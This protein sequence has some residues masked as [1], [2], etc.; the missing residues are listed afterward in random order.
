MKTEVSLEKVVQ[1]TTGA[2]LASVLARSLAKDYYTAIVE[3]VSNS[4]DADSEEVKISLN[5]NDDRLVISDDGTGMDKEGIDSFF[6]L[7]DSDKIAHPFTAKGRKK[8]GK[9]G[10]AT[11]LLEYLA[12]E[13]VLDTYKDGRRR[14]VREKFS[15]T[16]AGIKPKEE[17]YEADPDKHGT[18]ITLLGLNFNTSMLNRKKLKRVL[19]WQVP[20]LPDFNIHL[21]G[22]LVPKR[23]AVTYC[24]EFLLEEEISGIG[25]VVGS[26]YYNHRQKLDCPGIFIYVNGRAVGDPNSFNLTNFWGGLNGKVLGMIHADGLEPHIGFDR[27]RFAEDAEEYVAVREA[28][29]KVLWSVTHAAKNF[30]SGRKFYGDKRRL[31]KIRKVL[32]DVEAQINKALLVDE[33]SVPYRLEIEIDD[34]R[35]WLSRYDEDKGTVYINATNPQLAIAKSRIGIE[36]ALRPVFL[37]LALTAIADYSLVKD[38]LSNVDALDTFNQSIRQVSEQLYSG[39]TPIISTVRADKEDNKAIPLNKLSLNQHR[40]YTIPEIIYLTGRFPSTIKRLYKSGALK[41]YRVERH[42]KFNSRSIRSCLEMVEGHVPV[43][44]VLDPEFYRKDVDNK[45][46]VG[47]IFMPFEAEIAQR[48]DLNEYTINVGSNCPHVWVLED[49]VMEFKKAFLEGK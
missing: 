32:K 9:K 33:S 30:V 43:G 39:M 8:I 16:L 34:E 36:T 6:R 7:G 11:V 12:Q 28:I 42:T 31:P 46:T 44:L 48:T 41:P 40:L 38:G 47:D 35:N 17:V 13:Y 10:V 3:L 18:T 15:D 23:N 20:S 24:T 27:S 14:V 26:I 5:F 25:K 19:E 4:Y 29:E 22:I 2:N 45:K 49:K 21:D 1:R 37:M